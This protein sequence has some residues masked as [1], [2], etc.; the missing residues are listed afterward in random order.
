MRNFLCLGLM[1]LLVFPIS[2]CNKDIG[3]DIKHVNSLNERDASIETYQTELD[4]EDVEDT[5]ETHMEEEGFEK[6][7]DDMEIGYFIS[8]GYARWHGILFEDTD[9]YVYVSMDEHD[10]GITVASTEVSKDAYASFYERTASSGANV[11]ISMPESEE[12]GEDIEGFP[13]YQGFVRTNYTEMED[14]D[15]SIKVVEYI[16]KATFDDVVGRY[17]TVMFSEDTNLELKEGGYQVNEYIYEGSNDTMKVTIVINDLQG[18][19][20]EVIVSYQETL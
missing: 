11:A 6:V 5:F 19:Y 4:A 13:P 10:E 1:V 17:L 3:E 14:A 18:D 8:F 16:G 12:P 7:S 15:T 9:D 20:V 2:A